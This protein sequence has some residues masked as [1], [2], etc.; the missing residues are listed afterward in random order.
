MLGR[1]LSNPGQR[2][3]KAAKKVLRNLKSTKDLILTY[4]GNKTLGVVGFSDFNYAIS[5]DDKKSTFCYI[6][7]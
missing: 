5:V 1:Y 6:F 7:I 4:R 3:W 2:Y